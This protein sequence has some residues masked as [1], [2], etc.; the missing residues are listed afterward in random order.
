MDLLN[1]R[2]EPEQVVLGL[3]GIA[4]LVGAGI[5]G[6]IRW[7]ENQ[8]RKAAQ[9]QFECDRDVQM[10]RG[11]SSD[12]QRCLTAKGWESIAALRA[13]NLYFVTHH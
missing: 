9:D 12:Y 3:I 7:D 2:L 4:V 11:G 13:A 10:M 1:K 6:K 8:Q 5:W